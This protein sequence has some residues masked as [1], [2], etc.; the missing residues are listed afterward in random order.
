VVVPCGRHW[1]GLDRIALHG[2]AVRRSLVMA[3]EA[4]GKKRQTRYMDSI[5]DLVIRSVCIPF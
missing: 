2:A 1:I 5:P 4:A 3:V